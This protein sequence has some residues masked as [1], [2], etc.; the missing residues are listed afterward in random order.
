[1]LQVRFSLFLIFIFSIFI[2]GQSQ[3][4]R[5]RGPNGQGVYENETAPIS[6]TPDDV[7]WH[8]DLPGI[9][10]SSPVMWE[11]KLF[12]TTADQEKKT[13]HIF[14]VDSQDGKIL[15]QKEYQIDTYD[16]R[17]ESS[18]ATST[19]TVSEAF[20][21]VVF[22]SPEKTTVVALT[23][24]GALGWK[25]ELDGVVSRHGY[26][27]SPI[28]VDDKVIV[29]REQESGKDSPFKSTW[30]ALDKN[31]GETVWE[32]E[33]Q[34]GERNSFS[35]PC[36]V[37][38]DNKSGIVFTSEEGFTFVNPENGN[39]LWEIDPFNMRTIVSPVLAGDLIIG[40]CKG[41]LYAIKPDGDEK[42]TIAYELASKHSPYCSTPLYKD[43]LLFNVMDNGYIS[44]HQAETGELIWR[45]KPA[46]DILAAPVWIDGRLYVLTQKG[47]LVVLSAGKEYKLLAVNPLP[48]GSHATPVVSAGRLYLRTFSK[49][50]SVGK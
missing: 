50:L 2:Y 48:E 27:A 36:T 24:D 34:T 22:A 7:N 47:E 14:A 28:L 17:E 9:G 8:I 45:E 42:P 32:V 25:R 21:Y 44:C 12:V 33:R 29:T 3:N 26:G 20:V 37:T 15:W 49:L 39:I 16:I 23:H 30:L 31:T 46:D 5:Y 13:F 43:G 11:E 35:T 18:F 40:T 19:P 10:H 1:M 4:T 38:I 41:K 6:W